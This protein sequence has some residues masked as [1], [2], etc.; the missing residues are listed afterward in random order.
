[1]LYNSDKEKLK[2]HPVN[3][4]FFARFSFFIPRQEAVHLEMAVWVPLQVREN[5]NISTD[6]VSWKIPMASSP[7]A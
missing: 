2:K 3:K 7:K 5:A 6:E 4:N 1:M